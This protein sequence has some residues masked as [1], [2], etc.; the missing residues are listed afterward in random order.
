DDDPAE[1]LRLAVAHIE[2]GRFAIEPIEIAHQCLQPLV[3]PEIEQPPGQGLVA[4]PFA[5][6][7]EFLAHEQ[8]LLA[9]MAPHEAVIGARIGEAL[10]FVARHSGNRHD[11][12]RTCRPSPAD[13]RPSR[14]T[15]STSAT[16]RSACWPAS[17]CSP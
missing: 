2:R 5:G 11:R 15:T 12:P 7:A 14:A 16:A 6:L 17:I 10:P 8:Q 1:T 9:G 13:L 3:R 4:V